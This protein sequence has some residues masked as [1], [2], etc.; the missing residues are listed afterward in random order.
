M[1]AWTSLLVVTVHGGCDPG[2]RLGGSVRDTN[3]APIAGATAATVCAHNEPPLPSTQSDAHGSFAGI[4]V[5][6]FGLDC[7]IEVR[8]A[9]H[10]TVRYPVR[11]LC[12]HESL[13]SCLTVEVAAVL[14]ALPEA[15]SPAGTP[16]R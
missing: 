1:R 16:G 15:T 11:S 2:Y 7:D 10:A 6:F 5:G 9:G 14:T 8:A 12:T 4:G 13:G 3:G